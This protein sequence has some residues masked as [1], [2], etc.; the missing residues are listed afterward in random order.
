MADLYNKGYENLQPDGKVGAQNQQGESIDTGFDDKTNAYLN[1]LSAEER[2]QAMER[3]NAP[4]SGQD[5]YEALKEDVDYVPTQADYLKY[6]AYNKTHE[7][8]LLEGIGEGASMVLS[9]L[10]KAVGA[11]ADHPMKA[12]AQAPASLIEAFSQGTRN[13]YG[14]LAQSANPD[15]VLFGFKNAIAGDGSPEGYNQFLQA[16]KFNKHSARLASGEETLVMDK[17]VVDHDITLAMSY[18]ADPTLFIPFVPAASAGMKAVGLGEKM[19]AL[20][21]RAAALKSAVIGGGLKWGIGAPIEAIGKVAR[22]SIDKAV[23]IGG[24]VLETATGISAA[25]LR[26]TAKLSA[27]G[28]TTAS[29]L[30]GHMPVVSTISNVYVGAGVAAGVGEAIGA[31]G[32][33]M[34][35][36]GSKRGNLSFA[37]QALKSTP[38]LSAHARGLLRVIDAVDPMFSYAYG[39]SEGMAHGAAIG[40]GLGYLSGGKEGM[41]HGIGAGVALGGIGAGAGRVFADISGGT[42]MARAEV[43]GGFVLDMLRAKNDPN[44]KGASTMLEL[45]TVKGDR[46][47]GLQVLGGLDRIASDMRL[48]VGNTADS[49]VLLAFHGLDANGFKID[50]ATGRPVVDAQGRPVKYG[51]SVADWHGGEGFVMFTDMDATGKKRVTVHINTDFAGKNTMHHELFHAVFRTTLMERYFKDGFSKAILG[52]FDESGKKIKPSEVNPK[53]FRKFVEREL[54]F[55]RDAQGN[56]IP[57]AEVKRRLAEFDVHLG[58]Y[59]KAGTTAKMNPDSARALDYLV[60]EFGAHY[61]TQFLKGKSVDYLFHGGEY[62]G[63]RGVMDRVQN[64]FIDFWQSSVQKQQPTFDFSKGFDTAFGKDGKR[65]SV[66]RVSAIDYMAQDLIRSVAGKN[67]GSSNSV[68]IRTLSPEARTAFFEGSGIDRLK[69]FYDKNGKPRVLTEDQIKQERLEVGKAIHESLSKL[70]PKDVAGLVDIDGNFGASSTLGT[71][72]NDTML[73]HL[74]KEGHISQLLADRVKQ[75]QDVVNGTGSNV[76]SYLYQ[77]A[78]QEQAVG[79]NSPR[80]YGAD[81]PITSRNTIAIGYDIKVKKD[82]TLS[83][84]MLGLDKNVIDVRGNEQWA[85][86]E[87]RDLWQGDRNAFDQSFFDYLS[88]ASKASTDRTRVESSLIPS[89]SYGDGF[90]GERRNVMHQMLGLAKRKGEKYFNTP[91]AEIPRGKTSTVSRF[92]M[93]S[94]TPLRSDSPVRYDFNLDNA[95]L[96]LSKNFKVSDM[97]AEKTPIGNIYTHASGFK[98]VADATGSAHLYDNQGKA[99]GSFK[100][101]DLA[102][103]GMEKAYALERVETEKRIERVREDQQKQQTSFKVFD[104]ET[105]AQGRKIG[106]IFA[107]DAGKAFTTGTELIR[108]TREEFYSDKFYRLRQAD[109]ETVFSITEEI[110]N[111]GYSLRQLRTQAYDKVQAELANGK[112]REY[113]KARDAYDTIVSHADRYNDI[114]LAYERATKSGRNGQAILDYIN[115]HRRTT[116]GYD[117]MAKIFFGDS[118]DS[119]FQTGK[120]VTTVATHGTSSHELLT[121]REFDPKMFGSK[122][123]ADHDKIGVFLSG[124]TKTS[125]GYADPK[126]GDFGYRQVRAAVKFNNPLV[127]DAQFNCYSHEMYDKIFTQVRTGRHDGVIIKN[128]YDG[129]SADTVFVLMADKVKDNTA[130]IDAHIGME[131]VS[132]P[133]ETAE[134]VLN[135]DQGSVRYPIQESMPRGDGVRVGTE[136][137]LSW[138]VADSDKKYPSVTISNAGMALL[139]EGLSS[140]KIVL[141]NSYRAL[142][143]GKLKGIAHTPDTMA[144]GELK[145]DKKKFVELQGG[146]FFH[147]LHGDLADF[148]AST[149]AGTGDSSQMVKWLNE[150]MAINGRKFKT[151]EGKARNETFMT[152][153]KADNDKIFQSPAGTVS[154]LGILDHLVGKGLL[155]KETLKQ[156]MIEASKE[157]KKVTK[158]NKKTDEKTVT[159]KNK[160]KISFDETGSYGDLM[161]QAQAELPT[162]SFDNRKMF[163]ESLFSRIAN[164]KELKGNNYLKMREAIG[165]GSWNPKAKKFT[166]NEANR[167]FG[168]LLAEPMIRDVQ[169]GHAYAVIKLNSKIVESFDS[170][171]HAGYRSSVK[172]VSGEKPVMHIMQKTAPAWEVFNN[173]YNKTIQK[174]KIVGYTKT[175]KPKLQSYVNELG[176]SQNPYAP[177]FAKSNER[178]P[179]KV[180]ELAGEPREGGG[181]VYD[182]T[183]EQW[184]RGF[185]GRI[186]EQ[187]PDKVKGIDIRY[188]EN[189]TLFKEKNLVTLTLHDQEGQQIGIINA[190]IHRDGTAKIVDTV[191]SDAFSNKGYSKLML[192][193]LGERMRSQ[194]VKEVSGEIVD[195][196]DRPT[197]ARRSTF[198]NAELDPDSISNI[199]NSGYKTVSK[200]N[201]DA[202]YKVGD[203][204]DRASVIS[205][206]EDTTPNIKPFEGNFKVSDSVRKGVDNVVKMVEEQY[207]TAN[208]TPS[209]KDAV[210]ALKEALR[211]QTATD[212]VVV[213]ELRAAYDALIKSVENGVAFPTLNSPY[214]LKELL[215][216]LKPL[217][218]QIEK[219]SQRI[220]SKTQK[221]YDQDMAEGADLEGEQAQQEQA[222]VRRDMAEGADLES[223]QALARQDQRRGDQRLDMEEGAAV[224]SEQALAQRDE[225][226]QSQNE[227]A[228]LE[229]S[230]PRNQNLPKQF[231]YPAPPAPAGLPSY[232]PSGTPAFPRPPATPSLPSVTPSGKP[233]FPRPPTTPAL[234]KGSIAPPPPQGTPPPAPRPLPRSKPM[235]KLEGWRGWTLEKGLNG[236]FYKNAVGWMIIVQADKFKVYNPQRAMQGIYEDLESA[237]R[238]VQ[239]AEPKQ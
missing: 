135:S 233:A 138:K 105:L 44:L 172:Q 183:S 127:V 168:D 121:S 150:A 49:A 59:Q 178:M 46:A 177:I 114:I 31:V 86:T 39:I 99:L 187:N 82:G 11:M 149:F 85:K 192:S 122:H 9:D 7:S 222:D 211:K 37:A 50:K 155:S 230:E 234:P 96:D 13:L 78:S 62:T 109:A 191:V 174:S 35:K 111:R 69:R 185:I 15:S 66:Q 42:K 87:V 77:G 61:F 212:E 239:R 14:M 142:D 173:E 136:V 123:G 103:V 58:E 90:G 175:G 100:D 22:G 94:M 156:H 57:K 197:K 161:A 18:I 223:E 210:Y 133:A 119:Q 75:V 220:K 63:M 237:K 225:Y 140:G 34:L 83:L 190:D 98:I 159:I 21:G 38:N 10:G 48:L 70:D 8:S 23:S 228:D 24:N 54:T 26:T 89:L 130:I 189:K 81:V 165:D 128:V 193:E 40:G 236:G 76:F 116:T 126:E 92:S 52:E 160:Q 113:K 231:P 176:G 194:G 47:G 2:Q 224:D 118:Y 201:P 93:D 4:L 125:F 232:K 179:F 74:V 108:Q 29:A 206:G 152:L 33:Q 203:T 157:T 17:D 188:M 163:I 180:S 208:L 51:A 154:V 129:G 43:Q 143:I 80:L 106:D 141:S 184:K 167:V 20:G 79:P 64:S 151:A 3:I 6:V 97:E 132:R 202:H 102:G 124:E 217:D 71:K 170:K 120:A 73:A 144:V 238:R 158:T 112:G 215:K 181:R 146:M 229:A 55:T 53:E 117:N 147:M 91:I 30:G 32:E 27:V 72:F 45:A 25:E 198:G 137:G 204:G 221:G 196:M 162:H 214:V 36:Q 101:K 145:L 195:A 182:T 84:T 104:D 153:V 227:G 65:T 164:S 41:G 205:S 186:A 199:S 19:I 5:V 139:A 95:H 16:R 169:K 12:L 110:A 171:L 88:N 148:W 67:K 200:L 60:E 68:D 166:A 56:K 213:P 209:I 134:G 107:T 131:R 28:T 226:N 216:T 218:K 1:S 235:G 115:T 219:N 207:E